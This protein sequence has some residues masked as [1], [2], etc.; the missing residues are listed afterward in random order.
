MQGHMW[1]PA[2]ASDTWFL[3]QSLQK[4]QLGFSISLYLSC[5][6]CS[7]C[8]CTQ[9]FLV[10]Y[11]FFVVCCCKRGVPPYKHWSKGSQVPSCLK[12]D[13]LSSTRVVVICLFLVIILLLFKFNIYWASTVCQWK[14]ALVTQWYLTLYD[15][16]VCGPGFSAHGILQARILE[17]VAISSSRGSFQPRDRT[18]ISCITGGFFTHWVLWKPGYGRNKH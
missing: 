2:F 15:P 18:H 7:N 3:L 9:S 11:H 6:I 1:Y 12:C 13:F 10:P 16:M 5:D 8:A 4:W 17:W 14:K